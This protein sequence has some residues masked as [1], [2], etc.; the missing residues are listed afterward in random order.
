MKKQL[1][2]LLPFLALGCCDNYEVPN[3]EFNSNVKMII[4][5]S[6]KVEYDSTNSL[7][8]D[9]LT[10]TEK[11]YNKNNQ[12]VELNQRTLFDNETMDIEYEYNRCNRLLRESINLSFY[13]KM[14]TVIDYNYDTPHEV[15]SVGETK[16]DSLYFKQIG[17]DKYDADNRLMHSSISQIFVDL[18]NNDTVENSLQVDRYNKDQRVKESEFK[19]YTEPSKNTRTEYFYEE[20]ELVK[21]KY[22]NQND[23]LISIV[24]FEYEKDTLGNWIERKFFENNK[25]ETI[26]TRKIVYW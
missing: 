19:F 10:R 15:K 7:I 4:E 9:T 18:V 24:S 25:L 12:I 26:K 17:I 8:K 21:T 22:F 16:W 23:S 20:K 3:S 11:K 13:D 1:I 2:F 14:K 6:I 5:H